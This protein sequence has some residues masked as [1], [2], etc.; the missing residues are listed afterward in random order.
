MEPYTYLA[1][2]PGKE[3]RSALTAAFNVWMHV[4]KDDL[5]IVKKVVGMLH[6][7]SLL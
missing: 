6:T 1:A 3:F 7:A 4:A 5:D 2:I